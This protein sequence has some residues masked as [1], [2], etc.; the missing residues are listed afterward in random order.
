MIDAMQSAVDFF[1]QREQAL[2]L[3]LAYYF[4]KPGASGQQLLADTVYIYRFTDC[5]S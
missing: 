1:Q 4:A 3:V 2:A 5:H